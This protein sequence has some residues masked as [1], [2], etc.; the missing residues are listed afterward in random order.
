MSQLS[1]R[2]A[3][4]LA[5][6]LLLA[7]AAL[8]ILTSCGETETTSPS[9]PAAI[10]TSVPADEVPEPESDAIVP[11]EL[12][13]PDAGDDHESEVE[14][15][16]PDDLEPDGG[17]DESHG[18]EPEV[19]PGEQ[20]EPDDLEPDGGSDESH[21]SEP[22][23]ESGEP[24]DLEPA[25]VPWLAEPDLPSWMSGTPGLVPDPDKAWF[26]GVYLPRHCWGVSMGEGFVTVSDNVGCHADLMLGLEYSAE[27]I[28][29]PESSEQLYGVSQY[30]RISQFLERNPTTGQFGV[31]GQWIGSM[32]AHPNGAFNSIEG[33]LFIAD[34]MGRSRFPKYMASAA[35]HLYSPDSDTGGGWGFYERRIDCSQL[36]RVSLSNRMLIPPNLIAFDEDQDTF[37]DEGGI[38]L[39]TSWVALPIVGAARRFDG[40]PD[41]LA[42][43]LMSWTFVID[44]ANH[45]GPLF[46][47]A[48]EHWSRR[49]DRWNAMEVLDFLQKDGWMSDPVAGVLLDY[50]EGRLSSTDLHTAIAGQ[51]W[52]GGDAVGKQHGDQHWVRA[53]DTLGYSPARG[54]IPT[55]IEMAPVPAFKVVDEDGRTF[56]KVFPPLVPNETAREGYALNVQTFDVE[57]Y[58]HFLEVFRPGADLSALD[59]SFDGLGIPMQVE[60]FWEGPWQGLKVGDLTYF[61][62]YEVNLTINV[63]MLPLQTNGETDVYVD[64]GDVDPSERGWATFYEVV[65]GEAVEVG[66]DEVPDELRPLEYENLESPYSLAPHLDPPPLMD[67]SCWTCDDPATCDDTD[68]VAVLDDGSRITYRWFRFMDQPAFKGLKVEY[69]DQYSDV[70]LAGLQSVVESMHREWGGSRRFLERPSNLPELHLAEVDNGLL[71]EPPAGM[72]YG[73]VPMVTQVEQPGGTWIVETIY[74]DAPFYEPERALLR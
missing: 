73:W 71:V 59:T 43:G 6:T 62:N 51:E 50:I 60:R 11:T 70:A 4:R 67:F 12:R 74:R 72:E 16:E 46:F 64:W 68:H 33:G 7:A 44:A 22:E 66:V 39:G 1:D 25:E 9:D 57:V 26:P 14:S 24:D 15:G 23:V 36:G 42:G 61:N 52:Y 18:S 31:W 30:L 28:R 5:R 20:E 48:P 29:L 58:N 56:L 53:Q 45:S 63:P 47:Y 32:G 49:L 55:G 21:G 41:D 65:D 8:L 37:D 69:P 2:G 19:E 3:P 38:Y 17:S 10:A 54:Y 35:T 27:I 34:K 40:Q 13:D